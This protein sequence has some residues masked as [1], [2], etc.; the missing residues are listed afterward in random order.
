MLITDL[1]KEIFATMLKIDYERNKEN[2]I[3]PKINI[4]KT[5][6]KIKQKYHIKKKIINNLL[7][8][9]QD[10][11]HYAN[12][13]LPIQYLMNSISNDIVNN[14]KVQKILNEKI[15]NKIE[16]IYIKNII[17]KSLIFK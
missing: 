16:H 7:L 14:S 4:I 10:A 3:Y 11:S 17:I 9:Y 13:L 12:Q 5:A 6:T 2:N 1:Y 15:L 8:K